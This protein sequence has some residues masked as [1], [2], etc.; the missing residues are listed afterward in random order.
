[1]P[2]KTTFNIYKKLNIYYGGGGELK[3]EKIEFMRQR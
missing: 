2:L 1:M 3:L